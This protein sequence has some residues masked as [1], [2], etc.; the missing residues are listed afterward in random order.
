MAMWALIWVV[1]VVATVGIR[2]VRKERE[3]GLVWAYIG[4]LWLMHWPAAVIYL[5]PWYTQIEYSTVYAGFVQSTVGIVGYAVGAIWLGPWVVRLLGAPGEPHHPHPPDP[6]LPR[7]YTL[8]GILFFLVLTPLAARIPT[9]H[10][11]AAAAS[12]LIVVGICL[13]C[14]YGWFTRNNKRFYGSLAIAALMPLATVLG[15]GFLGYGAA[16]VITVMCFNSSFIR[17]RWKVG[18]VG[19][20]VAYLGFTMY[21]T[22]MRDRGEIRRVVWGGES[23]MTRMTSVLGTVRETELFNP[24]DPEH[25]E[26]I[27]MRLNQNYLVGA[28][29]EMMRSGARDFAHGATVLQAFISVI[30]R[31]LWPE[32]PVFGGSPDVVTKYTGIG[33][34]YGTSVGIGQ[35]MEFY[36][37]FGTIGVFFGFLLLGAVIAMFDSW[38]AQRLWVGDWQRFAMWF[39]ASLGFIQAGGSLVEVFSTVA[40]GM[41]AAILVNRYV[42]TWF[43]GGPASYTPAVI[44]PP[45]PVRRPL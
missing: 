12:Q 31:A 10:A 28:S 14:W 11:L 29:V 35:V 32:K 21:V 22:Y 43:H 25:L 42:V 26:R 9:F 41:L 34:A 16:T 18:L 36:I 37:N 1:A 15:Q 6:L 45:D 19:V 44:P 2:I 7:S 8:I 33:F 23:L 38:A 5:L 39:L 3:C 27:D 24:S 13:G 40:A 4:N 17:P 30:P 20:L